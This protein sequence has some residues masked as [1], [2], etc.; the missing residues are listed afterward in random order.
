[1]DIKTFCKTELVGYGASEP[2][3]RYV[4]LK[5]KDKSGNVQEELVPVASFNVGVGS[6]NFSKFYTLTFWREA[7]EFINN[8]TNFKGLAVRAIGELTSIKKYQKKDGFGYGMER[9]MSVQELYYAGRND[10]EWISV[11]LPVAGQKSE[12]VSPFKVNNEGLTEAFKSL[13]EDEKQKLVEKALSYGNKKNGKS[14]V[15]AGTETPE[16]LPF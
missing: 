13:P 16:D 11:R 9:K 4:A 12:A 5:T 6:D 2:E 8:M 14:A 7:A 3:I 15:A 1:L 10:S